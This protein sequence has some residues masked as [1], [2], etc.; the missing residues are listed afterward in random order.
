MGFY[1]WIRENTRQAVLMGVSDAID[2]MGD[3][4]NGEMNPQLV[5]AL[6]STALPAKPRRKSTTSPNGDGNRK[7]L[8]RSLNNLAP[9]AVTSQAAALQVVT[10]RPDEPARAA[11]RK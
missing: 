2:A 9:Q 7:R 8:G 1:D 3:A 10:S 11:L 6:N 5:A 4:D